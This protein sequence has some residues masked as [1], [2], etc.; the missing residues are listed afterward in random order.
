MESDDVEE[1]YEDDA[2]GPDD[3]D[4]EGPGDGWTGSGTFMAK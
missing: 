1:G 4:D 3:R 2:E